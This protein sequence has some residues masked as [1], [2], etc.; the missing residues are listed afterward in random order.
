MNGAA[1]PLRLIALL[2]LTVAAG[3]T[4]VRAE[5]G[6][7][8]RLEITQD[9]SADAAAARTARVPILLAVTRHDCRFCARLRR[10]ILIPMLLSGDYADKVLIRELVIEPSLP[11]TGF[12]GLATDS[13]TLAETLDATLSP[14]VLLLDAAGR[15]LEPPIRGINNAE[16]YGFYLDAAIERALASVR[17]GGA[18]RGR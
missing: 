1:V 10:E 2:C 4:P 15:S 6:S 8:A 14:T 18:S 5:P 3:G 17:A 16:F 7:V 13:E 9:L 12:D 11:V